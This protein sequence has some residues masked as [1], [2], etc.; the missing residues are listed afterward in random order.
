MVTSSGV[1]ILREYVRALDTSPDFAD[2]IVHIAFLP[3]IKSVIKSLEGM[4]AQPNV[5]RKET[6]LLQADLAMLK[7][8]ADQSVLNLPSLMTRVRQYLS[9]RA[10]SGAVNSSSEG[11][12]AAMATMPIVPLLI[13]AV[14][15]FLV[16]K[17]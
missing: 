8:V 3:R 1:D 17:K 9:T 13:T 2:P 15:I 6:A 4:L 12:K 10:E 11:S 7:D 16:I 14:F 5:T